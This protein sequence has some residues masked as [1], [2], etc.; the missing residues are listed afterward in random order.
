MAEEYVDKEIAKNLLDK[1]LLLYIRL[2]SHSFAK[3]AKRKIQG[4]KTIYQEGITN[5]HKANLFEP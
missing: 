4:G 2:R 1:L 3:K 5:Q